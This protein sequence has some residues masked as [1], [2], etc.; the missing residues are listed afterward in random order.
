MPEETA[1]ASFLLQSHS[2]SSAEHPITAPVRHRKKVKKDRLPANE[3]RATRQ[4]DR[5]D[6]PAS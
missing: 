6:L 5:D 4:S 2:G 1:V 3:F